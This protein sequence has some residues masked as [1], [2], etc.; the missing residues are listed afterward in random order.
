LIFEF[1]SG[2]YPITKNNSSETKSGKSSYD[3]FKI[4]KISAFF[5]KRPH[6]FQ[7]F[8]Q[9]LFGYYSLQE[10]KVDMCANINDAHTSSDMCRHL[11][12]QKNLQR[13]QTCTVVKSSW[14]EGHG[15]LATVFCSFS[16]F[17]LCIVI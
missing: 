16:F 2:K 10:Y 8:I 9:N 15:C 3:R 14:S 5:W 6:G 11:H 12:L 1:L 17:I 4:N 7:N 13:A